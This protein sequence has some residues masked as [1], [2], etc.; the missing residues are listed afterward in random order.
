MVGLR[1]TI[2]AEL[3]F[4]TAA[5]DTP[6]L[7]LDIPVDPELLP[8][9][10]LRRYLATIDRFGAPRLALE[11]TG[12]RIGERAD[13]AAVN[14]TA[15]RLLE[16]AFGRGIPDR[17]PLSATVTGGTMTPVPDGCIG[18]APSDPGTDVRL[19]VDLESGRGLRIA[20]E[21]GVVVDAALGI[22]PNELA[23]VPASLA[24]IVSGPGIVPPILPAGGVWHASLSSTDAFEVCPVAPA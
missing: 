12:F 13:T 8:Q 17:G 9:V 14:A 7:A 5:R 15:I 6:G 11:G 2:L 3:R 10:T 22:L 23:P 21:P 16:P 4:G 20:V 1:S 18:V 24:G 19:A